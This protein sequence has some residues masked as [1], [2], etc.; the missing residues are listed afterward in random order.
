M[1]HDIIIGMLSDYDH[2]DIVNM[3]SHQI[4]NLQAKVNDYEDAIN[5]LARHTEYPKSNIV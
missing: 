1:R 4:A 3:Q 5:K 2:T